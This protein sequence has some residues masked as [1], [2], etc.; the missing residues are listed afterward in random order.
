MVFTL[1]FVLLLSF[2]PSEWKNQ[3]LKYTVRGIKLGESLRSI[4][5]LYKSIR[6]QLQI[7]TTIA[8]AAAAAA[9]AFR[10]VQLAQRHRGRDSRSLG[11]SH[12][13]DAGVA[14]PGGRVWR[15]KDNWK[16]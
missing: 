16:A 10:L 9:T 3:R 8:T 4:L 1:L 15:R 2:K 11:L 7:A 6:A 12:Q 13:R 14:R 5:I